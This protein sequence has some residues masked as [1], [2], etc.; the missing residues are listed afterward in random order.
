MI[1]TGSS[2]SNVYDESAVQK[3]LFSLWEKKEREKKNCT[4]GFYVALIKV[5]DKCVEKRIQ[6]FII[7]FTC[8][9]AFLIGLDVHL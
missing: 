8:N 2:V 4:S 1:S 6:I 9:V 3:R 5:C 7:C